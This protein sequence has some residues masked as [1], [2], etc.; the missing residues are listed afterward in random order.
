MTGK[1]KPPA[2]FDENPPLDTDF[3]ANAAPAREEAGL[4]QM[5]AANES[6][7]Q[8][9][10]RAVIAHLAQAHSEG[11]PIEEALTSAQSLIAAE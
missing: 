5:H 10:L 3:F 11:V 8:A 9:R 2:D 4:V 1:S 7:E 6:E